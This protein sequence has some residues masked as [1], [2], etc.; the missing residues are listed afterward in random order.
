MYLEF[1][2]NSLSSKNALGY[3]VLLMQFFVACNIK[4]YIDLYTGIYKARAKNSKGWANPGTRR[5]P[6]N[7]EQAEMTVG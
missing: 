4:L 2:A 6:G 7:A 1:A 3:K 5:W